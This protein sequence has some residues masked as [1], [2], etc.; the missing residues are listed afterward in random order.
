MLGEGREKRKE[1]NG[2]GKERE[3]SD[4]NVRKGKRCYR[5]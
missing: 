2:D 5:R 3:R 4:M 1:L